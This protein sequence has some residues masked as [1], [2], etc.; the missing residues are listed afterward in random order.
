MTTTLLC[1]TPLLGGIAV[2]VLRWCGAGCNPS[3]VLHSPPS[4]SRDQSLSVSCLREPC[5][6][7]PFLHGDDMHVALVVFREGEWGSRQ[8]RQR[9][10]ILFFF[11]TFVGSSV[12]RVKSFMQFLRQRRNED[13]DAN[14]DAQNKQELS[15][16]YTRE[17][18]T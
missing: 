11:V 6:G 5:I 15:D 2:P 13:T 17:T 1:L 4:I 7:E 18:T 10:S 14:S 3:V 8:T 9:D 16:G 12:L